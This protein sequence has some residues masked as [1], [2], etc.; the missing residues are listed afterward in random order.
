MRLRAAGNDGVPQLFVCGGAV[1]IENACTRGKAG[2]V[3]DGW[4]VCQLETSS[5]DSC[6]QVSWEFT[7]SIDASKRGIDR[8]GTG[9]LVQHLW[10]PSSLRTEL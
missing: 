2:A 10:A 8:A 6:T 7:Y 4:T 1:A 5:D 3:A 9:Q